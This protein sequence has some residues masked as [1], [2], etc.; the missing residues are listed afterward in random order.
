MRRS[1]VRGPVP[2]L[3]VGLLAVL[4]WV[5]IGLPNWVESRRTDAVVIADAPLAVPDQ[6]PVAPPPVEPTAPTTAARGSAEP[7]DPPNTEDPPL[8]RAAAI[9][10]PPVATPP[11]DPFAVAMTHALDRIENGDLA[12]ARGAL[13]DAARHRPAD[14]ALA[15]VRAR[16]EAS[17]TTT[18]LAALR[19]EARRAEESEDWRGAVERYERALALDP[20]VRFARDGVERARERADLVERMSFHVAHPERMAVPDVLDD[21]ADALDQASTVA[22]VGPRHEELVAALRDLVATARSTVRVVLESDGRTEVA[23]YHVGRLGMFERHEL[24]LRPGSYTVV[25]SRRGYRDVRATL[26]VEPG[27]NPVA[28]RVVCGEEF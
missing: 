10:A 22:P 15:D 21:A 18:R 7:D 1:R 4:T 2:I 19:D 14:P 26:V 25:G 24:E 5:V 11:P 13:A 27:G 28:L 3:V 16:I 9:P 20:N 8:S 6:A 23:I 17:E 12:G